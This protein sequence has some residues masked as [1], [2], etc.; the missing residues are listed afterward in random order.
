MNSYTRDQADLIVSSALDI[1]GVMLESGAEV[2]RVEDTIERICTAYGATKVD[3]FSITSLIITTVQMPDGYHVTQSRR[4]YASGNQLSR[5]EDMNALSRR[6][7]QEVLPPE[8]LAALTL[9]PPK[10]TRKSI[11]VRLFGAVLASGSFAVFFGGTL[12]DAFCAALIGALVHLIAR[13]DPRGFNML[14]KTFISALMAGALAILAV[15]AGIGVNADKIMIGTIML[16]IPGLAFGVSLRDMLC[17]D[18]MAG[19]LRLIQTGLIAI[20]IAGGYGLALV[21]MGGLLV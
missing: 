7:C 21:A 3:V 4:V 9:A 20:V 17:G 19:S 1:A 12:A 11:L 16:L 8:E 14:A 18:I 13:S 15:Y 2:R 6:I 5:I 10:P